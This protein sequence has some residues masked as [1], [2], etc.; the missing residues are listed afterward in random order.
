M[1]YYNESKK[2]FCPRLTSSIINVFPS[3]DE[4]MYFL[5]LADNSIEGIKS[6]NFLECATFKFITNPKSA[7]ET[8]IEIKKSQ[9]KVIQHP[10]KSI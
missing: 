8:S 6:S 10:T 7:D 2:N 3:P 9:F 1:W 5:I 4:S